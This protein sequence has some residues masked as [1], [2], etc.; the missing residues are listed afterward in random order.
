MSIEENV[1]EYEEINED[2]VPIKPLV[3]AITDIAI[4]VQFP[5]LRFVTLSGNYISDLSPL[6]AAEY[7]MYLKSDHNQ[8]LQAGSLKTLN[9]LQYFDLSHNKVASTDY[10]NHGRLK[11]LILNYNEIST[12]KGVNGPPLNQFKLRSLETLEIRGNQIESTEGLGFLHDL[13]TLYF[14]ENL[15]K[16]VE[17]IS[18]LRGLVRLHLRDNHIATLDG[19]LQG[20]TK[21]EYLNLRGNKIN[22]WSEVKKLKSLVTLKV[23]V[24]SDNPIADRDLYR[25]VVL[26]MMPFLTR[27][28][29]DK[30]TEEE[31]A[32]AV[33][34]YVKLV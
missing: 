19:F 27:L 26:G 6:S 2:A 24:L 12:L 14:G 28:D 8:I 5:F 34:F 18:G 11:H 20:P 1:A 29:K 21:L 22:R 32:E 4:L 13:K 7:L 23:L 31:I 10:I 15:L 17:D 16:S 30:T 3:W 33:D 25:P 9:Y